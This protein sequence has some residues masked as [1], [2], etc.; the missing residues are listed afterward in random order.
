MKRRTFL[1]GTLAASAAGLAVSAGLLTPG[2]VM[3]EGGGAFDAKSMED[4][5]KIM[6]LTPEDSGDIKI[7]APEIAE[8]GA[9]VP[10][11]VTSGVAGTTEISILVDGN[12]TPLAATFILPEGTSPEVSTRIKMGK[13][14]NVVAIAKA[15]DKAYTAKQ[16]VKV[17]IGGCGG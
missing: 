5:L 16:E 3:A 2:M 8:N 9:V 17:T 6:A 11:T 7:K 4:A 1:Q 15:G 14:A 10:V 12:P 13:T